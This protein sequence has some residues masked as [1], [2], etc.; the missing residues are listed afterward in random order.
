MCVS[1]ATNTTKPN[2]CN[3]FFVKPLLTPKKRWM[4]QKKVK[5]RSNNEKARI[6]ENLNCFG[7]NMNEDKFS[8]AKKSQ[9]KVSKY[10]NI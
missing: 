5:K 3:F 2:V 4:P 7:L 9:R 6:C 8:K 10:L 1:R